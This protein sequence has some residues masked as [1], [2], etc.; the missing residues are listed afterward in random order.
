[1][2]KSKVKKQAS[3]ER[4]FPG[5]EVLIMFK[6]M[7]PETPLETVEWSWEVPYKIYEA[8]FSQDGRDYEVEILITGTPLLVEISIEA[9]E[10][11]EIV[12][13]SM[14]EKYPNQSI[15]EVERV[16]YSNGLVMYEIELEKGG[17]S[18]EV[19]YREDGKFVGEAESL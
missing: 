3:K 17:K 1:M 9:D 11:P 5:D 15:D 12:R 8:E 7:F 2:K 4:V 19:L 18:Y 16:E 10:L 13:K 6:E 14:R